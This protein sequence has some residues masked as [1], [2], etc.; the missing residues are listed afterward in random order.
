MPRQGM[1][2]QEEQMKTDACR[3]PP[4]DMY[5]PVTTSSIYVPSALRPQPFISFPDHVR[6][7]ALV[8][9]ADEF[10]QL[11]VRHDL[12]IQTDWQRRFV[13][14]GVVDG[15]VDAE[16]SVR[17]PRPP[18]GHRR[19]IRQRAAVDVEPDRK[20]TRLNSSHVSESRM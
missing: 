14:F 11:H 19:L 13:C 3:E 2:E 10:D 6:G 4:D 16:V 18:F 12:L 17:A 20:S 9:G 5:R 8:L 1:P 15:H 7:C